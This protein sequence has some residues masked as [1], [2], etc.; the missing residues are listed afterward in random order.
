VWTVAKWGHGDQ[1]KKKGK[2]REKR[3]KIEITRKGKRKSKVGG[4]KLNCK[5]GGTVVDLC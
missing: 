1:K 5:K 3:E 4:K 2:R